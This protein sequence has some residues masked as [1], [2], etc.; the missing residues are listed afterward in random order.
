MACRPLGVGMLENH[1]PSAYY[2][3]PEPSPEGPKVEKGLLM[4]PWFLFG[5]FVGAALGWGFSG[6]NRGRWF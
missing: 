4:D 2:P 1:T 3:V 6:P 5:L